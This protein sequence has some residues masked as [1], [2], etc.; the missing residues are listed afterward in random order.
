MKSFVIAATTAVVLSGIGLGSTAEAAFYKHRH[1][2]SELTR[3]E[4]VAIARYQRSVRALKQR[5]WADGRV[6]FWEK[7]R[8][9]RAEARHRSLVY[10]YRHN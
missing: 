9:K 2:K 5:A 3:W 8:I 4:R 10:R 6:T 1:G 7:M